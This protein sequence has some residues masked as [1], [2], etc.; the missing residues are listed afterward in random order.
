MPELTI[1]RKQ[2]DLRDGSHKEIVV[3]RANH[4]HSRVIDRMLKLLTSQQTLEGGD[5][6]VI[7]KNNHAKQEVKQEYQLCQ[8]CC[9]NPVMKNK[10]ECKPCIDDRKDRPS[11]V[12]REFKTPHSRPWIPPSDAQLKAKLATPATL[13]QYA[14]YSDRV[15]APVE[16]IIDNWKAGM[17]PRTLSAKAMKEI[18]RLEHIALASPNAKYYR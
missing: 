12:K 10:L 2:Y 13:E 4:K 9:A 7:V 14:Q 6:V 15:S 3:F 8:E 11:I 5:K 18:P 16:E 1:T 17:M